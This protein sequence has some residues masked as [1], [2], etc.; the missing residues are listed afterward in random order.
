MPAPFAALEAR[1]AAACLRLLANV[2]AVLTPVAS[3]TPLPAVNAVFDEGDLVVGDAIIEGPVLSVRRLD[4][5]AVRT[6][7]TVQIPQGQFQVRAPLTLGDGALQR[8]QLA[9]VA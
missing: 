3:G 5:P 7:D 8:I 9:R 2:E 6:G 1:S 4:W